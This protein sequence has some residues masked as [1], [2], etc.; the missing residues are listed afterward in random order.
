MDRV[1]GAACAHGPTS[2]HLRDL[3]KGRL[4]NVLYIY[5]YI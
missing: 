4:T 1:T 3:V 5:I 2:Q